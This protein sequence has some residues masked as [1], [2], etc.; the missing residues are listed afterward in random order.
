MNK[1]H[2]KIR[3]LWKM[4]FVGIVALLTMAWPTW[5]KLTVH[6]DEIARI[7]SELEGVSPV[8]ELQQI[9][10]EVQRL[11]GLSQLLAVGSEAQR[12][13]YDRIQRQL[14]QQLLPKLLAQDVVTRNKGLADDIVKLRN[15]LTQL[16]SAVARG[17]SQADELFAGYSAMV[18]KCQ[19]L[20]GEIGAVTGLE[21]DPE[22][23]T[24]YLMLAA[25]ESLPAL[26]ETAALMRGQG[27]RALASGADFALTAQ[28]MAMRQSQLEHHSYSLVVQLGR[29]MA[30]NDAVNKSI[31][32]E[33]QRLDVL[34][35]DFSA[36]AAQAFSVERAVDAQ[37]YFS[38][39][40][41][42]V[43]GALEISGT[44]LGELKSQLESRLNIET[45]N[46]RSALLVSLLMLLAVVATLA[47]TA[48]S[49]LRA[50]ARAN[51][52]SKRIAA[53]DLSSVI[54]PQGDADAVALLS[55]LGDMQRQLADSIARERADAVRNQRILSALDNTSTNLMIADADR[56]IIYMNKSVEKMLRGV[57][58]DMR[59]ALPQFSVDKM[60][61]T[62][63]DSFHRNPA[64]QA[65]LL[66]NLQQ[67]YASQINVSGNTFRLTASPVFGSD[68]KRLGTVVEWLDRTAEVKVEAEVADVVS[69]AAAGDFS[70]R[71]TLEGKEGFF[72][73][74]AEGLNSLMD[75]T[76]SGLGDIATVLGALDKGDLTARITKDYQG[77]FGELKQ[78]ANDTTDALTGM[79]AQI[80]E[81]ADTI[82][83]A[84]SEIAAGNA[85]LSSRTEQQASSLEETA[86]S[87]EELTSTVRQNA[88][89][90]RQAS[91]L[92]NNASQVASSGGAVVSDVVVTMASINASARKIS[93]II[94]VI[95]GIAFQTNILAL[96]AAV[97]AAR[98]GEQ[99]RGFAVVAGEVR[100]LAQRS[101]AAA[102]E[103]KALIS[104]SVEKV[105]A[106]NALVSKAGST[107]NEIVVAIK[108][109]TD[110]MAEIAAASAEQSTGIE[111]VNA[112][113]T[114]MD[115]MTQQ[116]A[117]LV[118]EA[119]ASA[120][121]LQSQANLLAQSVAAFRFDH[122]AGGS[123]LLAAPAAHSG[124]HGGR[125]LA[126]PKPVT[127]GPAKGNLPAKPVRKPAA[128]PAED[129]W[130]EF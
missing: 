75:T 47:V 128:R 6:K 59:K 27:S 58:A 46:Y 130:E 98:A 89:N 24:Y 23:D 79:M 77:T 88:D 9:I 124:G 32:D 94:S 120:E 70:Q 29:A 57:E 68:G 42:V 22:V 84:A 90:A 93:D 48:I 14:E 103:I 39:A 21:L 112:A 129:E 37:A 45:G 13:D 34:N 12:D 123:P 20:I 67:Q 71:L 74:L 114:Q 43:D 113:V 31:S 104:D 4:A 18:V 5:Q 86:S 50:F 72:K 53:G 41:A 117:A 51:E 16:A 78:Y 115:E 35:K 25:T 8:A 44:V 38:Q 100:T 76:A 64:H 55:A 102:K 80:R 85:D 54:E 81:A 30:A 3:L 92:A 60:I 63:I 10:A 109:V 121:S 97:E 36:L 73:T 61:G 49:V 33:I 91:G 83:T 105:D 65:N 52:L 82:H 7:Q 119:A 56:T 122:S 118:E 125:P 116:N 17:S 15:E 66:G 106:G 2:G 28:L 108:R 1:L 87:M 26:V 99:G 126:A 95:D 127:K 40:S 110:I 11:R 62:N 69:R 101:A 19:R 96:N 111:E 107:M